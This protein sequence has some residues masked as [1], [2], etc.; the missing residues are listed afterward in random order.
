[1]WIKT[2]GSSHPKCLCDCLSLLPVIGTFS[3]CKFSCSASAGS[4]DHHPP[5]IS[6]KF[7]NYAQENFLITFRALFDSTI[8]GI[9]F[10]T[11][12]SSSSPCDPLAHPQTQLSL[13][14]RSQRCRIWRYD[15]MF[16]CTRNSSESTQINIVRYSIY[17]NLWSLISMKQRIGM[18]LDLL[19][20]YQTW[21]EK[22]HYWLT[23]QVK[24]MMVQAWSMQGQPRAGS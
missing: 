23:E 12:Q 6:I 21:Y 24:N 7:S 10:Y 9:V 3:E 18:N 13:S 1:M 14:K 16:Y 5:Q 19:V 20:I 8:R 15:L 4:S 17:Q 2:V 11:H 22:K